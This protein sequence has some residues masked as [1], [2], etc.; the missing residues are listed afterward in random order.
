[1]LIIPKFIKSHY[2][3]LSE[4][5]PIKQGNKLVELRDDVVKGLKRDYQ[6]GLRTA[7][8]FTSFVNDIL[9]DVMRRLL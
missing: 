9:L 5:M 1:M 4:I 8:D 6:L 7:P 2:L 3:I